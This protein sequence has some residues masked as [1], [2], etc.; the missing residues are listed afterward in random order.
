MTIEELQNLLLAE[1]E[2]NNNLVAKIEEYKGS[3]STKEEQY[4]TLQSDLNNA[5]DLNSKLALKVSTQTLTPKE[6]TKPTK[7]EPK[8]LSFDEIINNL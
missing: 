3:L 2:K 8:V 7:Q 5:R 1:Q 6:E 4:K